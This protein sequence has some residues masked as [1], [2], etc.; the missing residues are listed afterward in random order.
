MQVLRGLSQ[1]T[2]CRRLKVKGFTEHSQV[3]KA[4]SDAFSELINHVGTDVLSF[5]ALV[6]AQRKKYCR[7]KVRSRLFPDCVA[8]GL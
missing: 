3:H 2:T 5:E 1:S 4:R 6:D 8:R 7:A